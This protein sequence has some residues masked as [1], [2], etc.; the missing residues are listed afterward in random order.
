MNLETKFLTYDPKKKL[1]LG[2]FTNLF[3]GKCLPTHINLVSS[4]TGRIEIFVSNK[5]KFFCNEYGCWEYLVEASSKTYALKD[6]RL[7]IID[8]FEK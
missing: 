3:F 4:R 7:H 8:D 1:F 5:C 2:S 6:H